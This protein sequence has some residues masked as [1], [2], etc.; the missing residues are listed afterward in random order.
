M[1]LKLREECLSLYYTALDEGTLFDTMSVKELFDEAKFEYA[2][3][4]PKKDKTILQT[5]ELVG[6]LTHDVVATKEKGLVQSYRDRVSSFLNITA[7]FSY[8]KQNRRQNYMYYSIP[9][10]LHLLILKLLSY[11]QDQQQHVQQSWPVKSSRK[12]RPLLEGLSSRD[13]TAKFTETT[14]TMMMM[15]MMT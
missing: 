5:E 6:E 13:H 14:T 9:V 1:G 10:E 7:F 15:M 8:F 3:P 4:T 2:Q 11:R 12:R